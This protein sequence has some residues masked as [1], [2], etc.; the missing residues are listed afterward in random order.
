MKRQQRHLVVRFGGRA[1]VVIWLL[2]ALQPPP[3][4]R[5]H[6]DLD[7]LVLIDESLSMPSTFSAGA[8]QQ[9]RAILD[10]APA[11]LKLRL[12]RF[13]ATPVLE[14]TGA[15]LWAARAENLPRSSALDT[16]STNIATAL[17]QALHL[18]SPERPTIMLLRSDAL[19]TEGDTESALQSIHRAGVPLYLLAPPADSHTPA[20]LLQDLQVPARVSVG[21]QVPIRLQ[22]MSTSGGTVVPIL[23]IDGLEVERWRLHMTP[24]ETVA[25]SY[26]FVAPEPG[27]RQVTVRL[28]ADAAARADAVHQVQTRAV[29]VLGAAPLLNVSVQAEPSKLVHSLRQAG[30]N[31]ESRTPA[32]LLADSRVLRR[33]GGIILEDLAIDDMRESQ[34]QRLIR[35]VREEGVGLLVLGGKRS[36]GAGAYRHSALE[37]ILP[38]TAEA[39]DPQAPAT[40]LFLLDKSGSMGR[41]HGGPDTFALARQAVAASVDML[42]PEDR[43]GII[44][45]A[46]EPQ[47]RL[48]VAAQRNNIGEVLPA[49]EISPGGGTRLAP[50]LELGIEQLRAT[51]TPQRLLVLVTDGF[52]EEGQLQPIARTLLDEGITLIALAVGDDA[53]RE[54]LRQLTDFN[55][56]R[57]LSVT[58]VATLPRL[59]AN[60]V[61]RQRAPLAAQPTPAFVVKPLP[62]QMA[63]VDSWPPLSA[64]MVS[65]ARPGAEVYLQSNTG[66]PLLATGLAGAGRVAVLPAGLGDWAQQWW[67]WPEFGAFPGGLARWL[68]RGDG[69]A[70]LSLSVENRP[71]QMVFTIDLLE[72]TQWA[73][74]E[75]PRLL[76]DD[77]IGVRTELAPALQAPG[78]Y[79]AVYPVTQPGLYQLSL[80]AGQSTLRHAVYRNATREFQN[81]DLARERLKTWV[82][83]GWI[84]PW[85]G[86]DAFIDSWPREATGAR[87]ALLLL[88]VLSYLLL[89][90]Y[91]RHLVGPLVLWLRSRFAR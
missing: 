61:A 26:R 78:R 22:I 57:V 47:I 34:W 55:D 49:L 73:S 82:S 5:F 2:L 41:E 60:T 77:P 81:A 25:L 8:G 19:A 74:K 67:Q 80:H 38:V 76:V 62:F 51:A 17:L 37:Q 52:A 39:A 24:G 36:F 28:A 30:W 84:K 33:V 15:D 48:P 11:Q 53:N 65:K 23:K 87:Q 70:D 68:A 40:I 6:A 58:D 46:D 75:Q 91:E 86:V 59:M 79:Q 10:A 29:N 31:V 20:F 13:A 1:L 45:F 85:P 90:A 56:G 9:I 72:D 71:G 89:L 50:A 69:A 18:V 4:P 83:R 44:A 43:L 27:V 21:E 32:Q 3:W 63:P 14:R 64:Y 54:T 35:S 12:L 7:L 88:A 66:D 42:L 16:T